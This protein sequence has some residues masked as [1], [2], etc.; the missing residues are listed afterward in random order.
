MP[1]LKGH[2]SDLVSGAFAL[3][4]DTL[5]KDALEKKVKLFR[6]YYEYPETQLTAPYAG[7]M[8]TLTALRE[9]G[10]RLAV[11]SNKPKASAVRTLAMTGL[12]DYFEFVAGGDSFGGTKKPEAEHV[13]KTLKAVG[14]APE[15]SVL[16]G[17]TDVDIEGARNAG[18]PHVF[19]SYGYS[20]LCPDDLGA[21]VVIHEFSELL[22]VLRTLD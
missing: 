5:S 14:A 2:A 11:C 6:Q 8:E 12:D 7:V 10:L 13:L 20:T 9:A 15:E 17:D 4:G 18:I 21:E 1:L 19:C 22:D 3:R 16:V